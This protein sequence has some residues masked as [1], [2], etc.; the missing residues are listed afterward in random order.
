M[1]L[2]MLAISEYG[3]FFIIVMVLIVLRAMSED[4]E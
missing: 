4:R 1:P 2:E 3:F